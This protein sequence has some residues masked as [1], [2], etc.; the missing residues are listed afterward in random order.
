MPLP[1][2]KHQQIMGELIAL[3]AQDSQC[4]LSQ[5]RSITS[6]EQ[7][8]KL[9]RLLQQYV[10]PKS[11]VLDWGC[12][13][14]H[15]SYFLAHFGYQ[16]YGYAFEDFYLRQKLN[17]FAYEFKQGTPTDAI[18]IPYADQQFDAVVSVGVLEHV[19]ETGGDETASLKEIFRL[20]KPGGYF[21]CY[22]LPNQYSW[23]DP[24]ATLVP[25]KH[26]HLYRY[27]RTSIQ[28]LCQTVGLDLLAVQ[29]YGVLP[30]N[31][32]GNLPKSIRTSTAIAQGWNLA[33]TTLSTIFSPF[34]QNYWFVAQKTSDRHSPIA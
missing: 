30:R 28:E 21:I 25:N 5:F 31:F 34:C 7:Y 29:R 8:Q 27:T 24:I 18:A 23:I 10:A 14:G 2:P 4:N 22:H 20:L 33:D 26:H 6:A 13:N 15:F 12:G 3:Q 19:R 11:A 17:Q 32:W 9:Y 1:E 16:A